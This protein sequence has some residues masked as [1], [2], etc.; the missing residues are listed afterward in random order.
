MKKMSNKKKKDILET[1]MGCGQAS[2]SVAG[3][4]M[5]LSAKIQKQQCL[6]WLGLQCQQ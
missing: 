4:V 2:A 6:L 1:A 5:L 3:C